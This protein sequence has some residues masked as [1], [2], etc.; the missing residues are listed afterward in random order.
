[1]VSFV[2]N[3]ISFSW[4]VQFNYVNPGKCLYFGLYT[5]NV[6]TMIPG[7]VSVESVPRPEIL[8]PVKSGFVIVQKVSR[9]EM[10][11]SMIQRN[12]IIQ[13]ISRPELL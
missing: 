4:I 7:I 11:I 1:M 6:V 5:G 9:P 13:R 3:L 2:R 10:L 12:V 8:T